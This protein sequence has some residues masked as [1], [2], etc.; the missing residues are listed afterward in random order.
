[1]IATRSAE[2]GRPSRGPGVFTLAGD[3]AAKSRSH[4]PN[5]ASANS[6]WA[7]RARRVVE[8][9]GRTLPGRIR[10][11]SAPRIRRAHVRHARVAL[12]PNVASEVDL[13]QSARVYMPARCRAHDHVAPAAL[14]AAARSERCDRGVGRRCIEQVAP[15][16][17]A[18]RSLR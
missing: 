4:C 7:S 1:V 2:A 18:G 5:R 9:A 11:I 6:A 10:E 8:Q 12:D 3:A 15:H 13:G 14:V 17:R 16:A